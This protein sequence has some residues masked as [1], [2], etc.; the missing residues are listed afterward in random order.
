M[1]QTSLK[2]HFL[3]LPFHG[4][5]E[6]QG[7]QDRKLAVAH[8]KRRNGRSEFIVA[9]SVKGIL[10]NS[11]DSFIGI[12]TANLLGSKYHIWDQVSSCT[13]WDYKLKHGAYIL[14]HSVS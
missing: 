5:Q 3:S 4:L 11:D 14:Y 7:R 10:C 6:G 13:F 8:H 9:Q 2:I 1:H 12:V